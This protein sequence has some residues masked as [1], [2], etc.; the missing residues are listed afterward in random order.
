[1]P[2]FATMPITM[3]IPMKEDTL[4]SVRVMRSATK[5]PKVESNA[6]ARIATGAANVRNS[7]SSTAKSN[8][9]REKQDDEKIVK[10]FLL[11]FVLT[12]VF[13]AN[14][15]RQMQIVHGF[16][17]SGDARAEINA[18]QPSRD[19]NQAL[20]IFAAN[21]G[22]AGIVRDARQRAERRSL[23]GSADEQRVRHSFQRLRGLLPG[24][25]TR[26]G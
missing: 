5:A 3:I 26:M 1:M 19:L 24:K 20:Q 12:T 15:R 11:L 16:L 8:K 25:R 17:N 4:K 7:N 21:F 23:A 22:F 2:F 14:R 18:F 13:H 10:G 6:E 9:Q